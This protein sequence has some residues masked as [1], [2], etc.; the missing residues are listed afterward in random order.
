M[1]KYVTYRVP[2]GF[3]ATRVLG[4]VLRREA[5]PFVE[6]AQVAFQKYRPRVVVVGLEQLPA[7]GPLLVVSNHYQRPGMGAEWTGI[8]LSALLAEAMPAADIRWM[9]TDGK[10]GYRIFDRYRVPGAIAGCFMGWLS[11]RYGFLPVGSVDVAV[12]AP[13]L[14]AA[15]RLLHQER[16]VVGIMPEG[17]NAH[18][19]GSM[20][21]AKPGAG[22]SL[23][24]LSAGSVPVVPV[25]V[26]DAEDG[27]LV[28]TFGAPFLPTPRREAKTA[29]IDASEELMRR[30]AALLPPRLHG[31]YAE[32]AR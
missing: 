13:M 30:I 24:W 8:A 9:H 22:A 27:T 31:Y 1:V 20:G 28:V 32:A 2:L 6:D 25:A 19:D 18:D 29:G 7:S 3:L 26:H 16:R 17:G 11:R 14:R 12:R 15:Y 21:Q 4:S 23:A 5:R 10:K